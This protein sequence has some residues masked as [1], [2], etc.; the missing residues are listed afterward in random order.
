[1]AIP[2]IVLLVIFTMMLLTKK[3]TH[4]G[5][6]IEHFVTSDKFGTPR[7]NTVAL[8][9][10][11]MYRTLKDMNSYMVPVGGTVYYECREFK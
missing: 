6:V 9:D 7:Y 2:A 1:M 8:F 5:K 4:T 3:V 10:D 11:N